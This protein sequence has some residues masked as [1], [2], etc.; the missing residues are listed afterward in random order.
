MEKIVVGDGE[1]WEK[2]TP[3]RQKSHEPPDDGDNSD[4][5][6]N[7]IIHTSVRQAAP[8]CDEQKCVYNDIIASP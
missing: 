4:R 8:M 6:R 5:Y 7:K 3:R 2:E 1:G